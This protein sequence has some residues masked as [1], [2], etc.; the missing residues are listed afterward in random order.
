MVHASSAGAV[1]NWEFLFN[2]FHIFKMV[3]RQGP[4]YEA[5]FEPG[6]EWRSAWLYFVT[7]ASSVQRQNY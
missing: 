6:D 5:E 7:A 1:P 4:G 3:Q 2:S